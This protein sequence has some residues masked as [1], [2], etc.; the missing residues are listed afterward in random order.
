M[1]LVVVRD[2]LAWCTVFNFAALF[3]WWIIFLLMGDWVCRIHGRM[4]KLP[5]ERVR[6]IMYTGMLHFKAMVFLFTLGP[7][8]ALRIIG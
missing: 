1:T 4:F 5:E 2:F 8:L 6:E 3:L 7:Y